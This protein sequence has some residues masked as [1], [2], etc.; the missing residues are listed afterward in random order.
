MWQH[1]FN[2]E[3]KKE[4]YIHRHVLLYNLVQQVRALTIVLYTVMML[5]DRP[6]PSRCIAIISGLEA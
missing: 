2:I 3:K 4:I 5:H 1:Q 6:S